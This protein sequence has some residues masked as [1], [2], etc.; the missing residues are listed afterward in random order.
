LVYAAVREF[1]L[2]QFFTNLRVVASSLGPE[3]STTG[4]AK[5]LIESFFD[6][7]DTNGVSDDS[8]AD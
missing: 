2:P 7:L 5:L 4:A 3:S 8:G 6:E 1:S